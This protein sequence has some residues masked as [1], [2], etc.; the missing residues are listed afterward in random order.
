M[1]KQMMRDLRDPIDH[2]ENYTKAVPAKMKMWI[3]Q[4]TKT[5]WTYQICIDTWKKELIS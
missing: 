2:P 5:G 4:E 1:P 3:E